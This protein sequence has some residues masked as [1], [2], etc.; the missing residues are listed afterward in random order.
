MTGKTDKI[1]NIHGITE[2]GKQSIKDVNVK[3]R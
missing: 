3:Q 1:T 2:N